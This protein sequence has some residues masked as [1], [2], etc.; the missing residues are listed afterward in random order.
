GWNNYSQD[1][2]SAWN[3]GN[4]SYI[5]AGYE[6]C[7]AVDI[8]N[9][10]YAAGLNDQGQCDVDSITVTVNEVVAGPKNTIGIEPDGQLTVIGSTENDT[11]SVEDWQL[12]NNPPEADA[13]TISTYED[14]PVTTINVLTLADDY[15]SQ[16]ITVVLTN[17]TA[18]TGTVTNHADG[19]YTYSPSTDHNGSDSF[20]YTVTDSQTVNYTGTALVSISI[21]PVNDPPDYSCAVDLTVTEDAST[22][23]ITS[24]ACS[25]TAGAYNEGDQSLSL[26]WTCSN[27]SLFLTAPVLSPLTGNASITGL[28]LTYA[29][30]ADEYGSATITIALSDNGGLSFTEYGAADTITRSYVL[31]S[32]SVNDAPTFTKGSDLIG[33]LED[34][35][36]QVYT[37]WATNVIPIVSNHANESSQGLTFTVTND[38]N[39]LFSSQP[40]IDI[41]GTTGTLSYTLA[42]DMYGDTTVTV[43]LWDDGGTANGGVDRVTQTFLINVLPVNDVP[44]FTTGSDRVILE[45]TGG[46]TVSS[47]ATNFTQGA[48]NETEQSFTF[49][50]TNSCA[51]CFSTQP[52][53]LTANGDLTYTL[54]ADGSGAVTVWVTLMDD[55]G[56]VNGG[57]DTITQSFTIT[58][59]DINDPPAYTFSSNPTVS[60]G[61][62]Y[63][64]TTVL[65]DADY[66][67]TTVSAWAIDITQGST[68]ETWQSL[69]FSLTNTTPT[70]FL[71]QPAIDSST[72]NLSY[73]L[74]ANENG[75][76]TV[77]AVLY[78]NGGTANGGVDRITETFVITVTPV[79]DAPTLTTGGD[80]TVLEDADPIRVTD[81]ATNIN[82]GADNESAQSL[83]FTLTTD[84]PSLFVV[85][86]FIELSGTTS[87]FLCYTLAANQFGA[88]TVTMIVRDYSGTA[89]G[90]FDRITETF[91]I[92]VTPVS[93]VPTITTIADQTVYESASVGPLTFE[94]GDPDQD[95]LTV[96]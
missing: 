15:E 6:H 78:D 70:L 76:A 5:S 38:Y 91:M 49:S 24:W 12:I 33:I 53:V 4:I 72:G 73:T 13:I 52:Y 71:T 27:E 88:A 69:T 54:S 11:A 93:D 95:A 50:V 17:P 58:I 40:A 84:N 32:L 64:V 77:T 3:Q 67:A 18:L 63:T 60:G 43:I 37:D 75:S 87:G 83:G 65:E 51:D 30:G 85:S 55:G 8:S 45:N 29:F 57:F 92:T 1:D 19:T 86:P 41:S 81:W 59:T 47:W 66:T 31:T 61:Y 9:I 20:T 79:N 10:P 89:N 21:T 35:V 82:R 28:T 80:Q 2:F 39:A 56:T 23:C 44:D 46:E 22:Q 42:A 90:G 34:A 25:L 16:T 94:I 7:V 36:S 68:F 14:Y 48:F 26:T 62:E 96:T 74:A